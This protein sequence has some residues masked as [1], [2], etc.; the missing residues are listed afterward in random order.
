M[1]SPI[2]H[3]MR[4]AL[5]I[6]AGL[7]LSLLQTAKAAE[8]ETRPEPNMEISPEDAEPVKCFKVA[9]RSRDT[10][11]LGLPLGPAVDLCGGTRNS[12]ETLRCFRQAYSHPG[13]DG[14]G[15]TLGIAV[16]LCS[17]N[18]ARE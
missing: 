6:A 13:D 3:H 2:P 5:A 12:R 18:P 16:R 14:L 1:A 11:G 15:L 7:L 10:Q 17:T 8:P 9:W 4:V